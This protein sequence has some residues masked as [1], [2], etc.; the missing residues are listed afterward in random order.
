ML[1]EKKG[2]K[3][4]NEISEKRKELKMRREEKKREVREIWTKYT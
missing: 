2:E 3:R 1:N 4:R